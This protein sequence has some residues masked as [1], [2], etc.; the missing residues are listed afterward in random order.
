MRCKSRICSSP[1]A[2]LLSSFTKK[3]FLDN[4]SCGHATNI[5]ASAGKFLQLSVNLFR[6]LGAIGRSLVVA[7]VI[8]WLFFLLILLLAGFTLNRQYIHPWYIGAYW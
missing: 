4:G 1:Y 3:D 6:L 5:F 7:Y 2:C 8:A